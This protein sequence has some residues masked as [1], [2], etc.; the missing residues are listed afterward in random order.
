MHV[1]ATSIGEPFSR[2]DYLTFHKTP[3]RVCY[4]LL[5]IVLHETLKK[6][7]E[8]LHLVLFAPLSSSQHA[9]PRPLPAVFSIPH[10]TTNITTEEP[11][12]LCALLLNLKFLHFSP[13]AQ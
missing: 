11:Q 2:N 4:S 13:V 12:Q 1:L 6:S 3:S 8:C 7:S 10:L 5:L 9:S